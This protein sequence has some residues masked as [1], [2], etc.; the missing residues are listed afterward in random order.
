MSAPSPDR[1]QGQ[2]APLTGVEPLRPEPPPLAG[3]DLVRFV[4]RHGLTILL[5]AVLTAAVT[6]GVTAFLLPPSFRASATLV[7]VPPTFASQLK[8]PTMSVQ[9]YRTLLESD[10]VVAKLT[11]KLQERDLLDTSDVL[12]VGEELQSHLFVSKRSEEN[13]LAPMIEAVVEYPDAGKAARI[14]NTWSEV[15]LEHTQELMAK[16]TTPTADFVESQY[17]EANRALQDLEAQRVTT[18]AELDQNLNKVTAQWERKISTFRRGFEDRVADFQEETRKLFQDQRRKID[19]LGANPTPAAGPVVDPSSQQLTAGTR[20]LLR[21]ILVVR[22]Q[23]A[24]TPERLRLEKS[25]SDDA[26]WEALTSQGRNGS[27]AD[28]SAIWGQSLLSEE[29]NP[30]YTELAL[31]ATEIEIELSSA[32][33]TADER[34]EEFTSNLKSLERSRRTLLNKL[35]EE[36]QSELTVLLGDRQVEIDSVSREN[37]ARLAEMDRDVATRRDLVSELANNRNQARIAKAQEDLTD[38]RLGAAAVPPTR[39]ESKRIP[40]KSLVAALIAAIG[41]FTVALFR[42]MVN[43]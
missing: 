40:L 19:D 14:A 11:R 27:A 43:R 12:R 6:A 2:P 38:I 25:I 20:E 29:I 28:S 23:L 5:V 30:T 17:Q 22:E 33:D 9:G 10:A 37:R 41:A 1:T 15:F 3:E 8:P 16:A 24:Q 18:S 13:A 7:V 31:R 36:R 39:P 35:A 32:A 42:E 26:L 4:R 21:R 34:I